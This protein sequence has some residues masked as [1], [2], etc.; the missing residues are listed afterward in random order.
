VDETEREF[1]MNILIFSLLLA[2]ILVIGIKALTLLFQG[3]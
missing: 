3:K 2:E 1:R